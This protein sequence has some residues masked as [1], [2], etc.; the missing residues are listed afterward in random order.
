MNLRI[1]VIYKHDGSDFGGTPG[2]GWYAIVYDSDGAAVYSTP[3]FPLRK[4][5][6]AEARQWCKHSR[7]GVKQIIA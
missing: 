4:D 3:L 5:A 2:Q 1:S 7:P 6:L